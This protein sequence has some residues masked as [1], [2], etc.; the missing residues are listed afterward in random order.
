VSA[1]SYGGAAV[2][3]ER[4]E[5]LR[6]LLRHPLF[7]RLPP[8]AVDALAAA[9][10]PRVVAD[11]EAICRQGEEGDSVFV[12]LQGVAHVYVDDRRSPAAVLRRGDVVGE[13]ALLTGEPRSADVVATTPVAVLE[14]DAQSFRDAVAAHPAALRALLRVVG[15]RLRATTARVGETSRGEVVAV[16]SSSADVAAAVADAAVGARPGAVSVLDARSSPDDALAAVDA[17]LQRASTVV[18]LGDTSAETLARVA[19]LADRTIAIYESADE[20]YRLRGAAVELL[21]R[22]ADPALLGR[23]IARTRLGV[24]LGAGGARG[25]AHVGVLRVLENAGYAVDA[26]AGSSIG[27]VVGAWLALGMDADEMERTMRAT[28]SEAAVEEIFHRTFTGSATGVHALERALRESTHDATFADLVLP[29]VVVALDLEH[30]CPVALEEGPLWRAL[31]ASTALAGVFPPVEM[32][33]LR[34]VDAVSLVPVPTAAVRDAGSDVVVAVNVIP[35]ETLAAWPDGAA[36]PEPPRFS[37][38]RTLD[39]LLEVLDLA[40]LDASERQAADAEVAIRPRFGPSAWRDF[41]LGD[42]FR[43]AGAEAALEALPRLEARIPGR[44]SHVRQPT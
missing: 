8:S 17:E 44:R 11:G 18:V 22:D 4:D 25:H 3:A 16:L 39:A 30:G 15:D 41:H 24:A 1:T 13:L 34:L 36:A 27:A 6:V 31:L 23:R 38:S 37:G 14:L 32:D 28:F 43:D 9:A 33:A 7:D 42:R 40:Q 5:I 29:L 10:H 12:L 2:P 26:V 19:R 21:P 20:E 35:R